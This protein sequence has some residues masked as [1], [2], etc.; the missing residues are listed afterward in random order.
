MPKWLGALM[1]IGF[2]GG[3]SGCFCEWFARVMFL[4]TAGFVSKYNHIDDKD[5]PFIQ[6]EPRKTFDARTGRTIRQCTSGK[7]SVLC[8]SCLSLRQLCLPKHAA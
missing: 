7:R 8:S 3:L 2:E 6:K 5:G 1:D 4:G